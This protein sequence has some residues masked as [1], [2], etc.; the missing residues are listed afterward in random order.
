MLLRPSRTNISCIF[1]LIYVSVYVSASADWEGNADILEGEYRCSVCL[2]YF[3]AA[4]CP[5]TFGL[6]SICLPPCLTFLFIHNMF[7]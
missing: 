6:F 1:L 7:I 4:V 2:M 5:L 3:Y